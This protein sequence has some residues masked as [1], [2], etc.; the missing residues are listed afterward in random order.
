LA[1]EDRS[2]ASGP[3]GT[4]ANTD[5]PVGQDRDLGRALR[6]VYDETVNEGIPSEMLDLLGR[7]G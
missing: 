2:K 1:L 7:L 4:P 3:G 6:K 5:R